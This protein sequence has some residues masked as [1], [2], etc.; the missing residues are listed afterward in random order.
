M[1]NRFRKLFGAVAIVLFVI[2][3]SLIALVLAQSP[4]VQS[5]P[6]WLQI[7]VYALLG[8][9]WILPVMPV[10]RW[11]ETAKTPRNT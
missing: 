6:K 7:P 10:I 4:L 11:M 8:L 1:H 5:W 2:V 3:Y 9:G